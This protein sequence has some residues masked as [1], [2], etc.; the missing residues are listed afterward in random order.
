MF[1]NNLYIINSGTRHK[2]RI[3]AAITCG[4]DSEKENKNLARSNSVAM[5]D[6]EK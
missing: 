3:Y 1:F 5:E 2:R 6:T 4:R